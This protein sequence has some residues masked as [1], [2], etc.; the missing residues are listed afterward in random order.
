VN[1]RKKLLLA[2]MLAAASCGAAHADGIFIDAA[3]RTDMVYDDA[4]GLIYIA[5]G[6]QVLRY[7]VQCGCQQTPI[8]LGGTLKGLDLSPDGTTL[9]VADAAQDGTNEWVH[10]VNLD[11]L[12]DTKA[13]VAEAVGEYGTYAVSYAKD[14]SLLVTSN[15]NGSG[16]APLRRLDPTTLKWT[17]VQGTAIPLGVRQSSM[18]AVSGDRRVYAIAE[19]NSSDGPWDV[20]FPAT[21][22]FDPRQLYQNGTS[23][24]NYEIGINANGT[25]V[26]IPTYGGTFFYDANHQKIATLGE[27]AGAQPIGVAYHPAEPQVFLPWATTSQVRVYDTQSFQMIASY[28]FQDSF[29]SPGNWSFVQGRTRLSNDGSLLMVSVTGGVRYLRMYS[30]LSATPVSASSAGGRVKVALSGAV[31][32]SGKLMYSVATPPAH[33]KAFV[34]GN[35]LTYVPAPG[36]SGTDTFSYAVRYGKATVTAP[37]TMTVTANNAAYNP[38]VS[39]NTLPVLQPTT[40]VPGSTHV[41]GDFN[42]DGTSDLLWFN[43]S[44]SKVGYW[45]MSATTTHDPGRSAP[46]VQTGAVIFDV[47]PG[48]FVAAAG[49]LNGDGFT[50]LVFT[51]GNKDLW[52]WANDKHGGF[53]STQ[54]GTYPGNWQLVGSGDVDGDGKDDLLWLNPSDC[55]FGYWIMQGAT[56]KSLDVIPIPCGYY[57][58]GVGYYS[59]S[60]YVSVLWS[61]AANDLY[62]WDSRSNWF[63]SYDLS[64]ALTQLG[65]GHPDARYTWAVG[66]GSAGQGIGIEWFNSMTRSGFGASLTRSFDAGGNQTSYSMSA[67]WKGGAWLDTPDTAGYLIQGGTTKA[68]ALYVIDQGHMTIGT[69]GLP[70]DNLTYSGSAPI[71]SGQQWIYPAGWYVIGAPSNGATPLPWR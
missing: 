40:P 30:P 10:L 13:T 24:F 46:V 69:S 22:Q 21:G 26:A 19:P 39:F 2:G 3:N 12:V 11:S 29:A 32:N 49:D 54:I 25:Q 67:L 60:K 34:D 23:W 37:V 33:G 53:T 1:Q 27:Y 36:Y 17:T 42:G 50:D 48:Y 63:S 38:V 6:N 14:G 35:T 45:T 31:G 65:M 70:V 15:Y 59:S 55:Q 18:V 28:D 62:V 8:P 4:R 52:L 61:S 56:L 7:D 41:P 51:S 47:T 58:V 64:N 16:W 44:Q 5:N 71:P 68:S 43:P 20:Y 66:G 9:A 57:P